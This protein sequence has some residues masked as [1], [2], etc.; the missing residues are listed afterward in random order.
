MTGGRPAAA[1]PTIPR[2]FRGV[3]DL[4]PARVVAV[5]PRSR[6]ILWSVGLGALSA[7]AIGIPAFLVALLLSIFG[8]LLDDLALPIWL[9]LWAAGLAVAIRWL[10]RKARQALVIYED[11]VA[12][13]DG[14]RVRAWRWDELVSVQRRPA[15]R[16]PDIP[17][18]VA[19][20]AA[21]VVILA[22]YQIADRPYV[23]AESTYRFADAA[24]DGF[25]LDRWLPGVDGLAD[26]IDAEITRRQLPLVAAAL[27]AGRAVGFGSIALGPAGIAVGSRTVAWADF[28]RVEVELD[29]VRV[30][31]A[32][33]RPATARISDVSNLTLLLAL[34][35]ALAR[36]RSA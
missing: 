25:V 36:R 26:M 16:K 32:G 14:R 12:M 11:G 35:R 10:R 3:L 18:D 6:R 27:E 31:V 4:G 20:A 21:I 19:G 9:A 33:G 28:A 34:L 29:T 5:V 15:V 7:I 24:G 13:A 2:E 1:P 8:E 23:K 30:V 22:V 17:S